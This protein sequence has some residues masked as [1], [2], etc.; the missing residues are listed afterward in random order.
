MPTARLAV[1]LPEDVWVADLSS[2]YP[3]AT[4]RVLAALP[5]DDMGVGLVEITAPEMEAV[6]SK[7]DEA[8]GVRVFELLHRGD[9]RALVQFETDNPLLLL[10]I[11]NSRTPFEPPITIV[12]GVADLELTASRDRLSSLTDQLR[13]VGLEFDVRSVRTSMDPES[14]VTDRQ[15]ALIET[16]VERGYYDTPRT[17][18]LTGLAD[19]L[20]IAK[21][22]ASERLHRAEGAIIRAFAAD[23]SVVD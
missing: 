5:D 7:L 4:F 20:D 1:T 14:V 23:T 6:L 18:T 21:S 15:R 11:R 10:S 12:D 19:H 17:C 8:T 16:A 2:R 9:G 13:T 3:E 22:T